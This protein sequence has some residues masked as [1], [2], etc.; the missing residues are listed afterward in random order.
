MRS[1]TMSAIAIM[2]IQLK[3]IN[4]LTLRGEIMKAGIQ[5]VIL[6]SAPI[7]LQLSHLVDEISASR[8]RMPVTQDRIVENP[9]GCLVAVPGRG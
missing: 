2:N 4:Q 8:D 9:A 3:T 5:L 1:N 6:N 7:V